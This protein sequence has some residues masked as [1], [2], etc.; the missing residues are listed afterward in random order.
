[1]AHWQSYRI[2]RA[3]IGIAPQGRRTFPNLTVKENLLIGVRSPH[4]AAA[5][6]HTVYTLFLRLREREKQRAANLSGGEQSMLAVGRSL[7]TNP[8]L[9][10]LDEPSEGLAP[11]IGWQIAGVIRQLRE[12]GVSVLIVE[13]NTAL[14]LAVADNVYILQKGQIAFETAPEA[15]R[16]D[17]P[18][19]QRYLSV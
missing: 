15:L 1:V 8:Q 11:R 18:L 5:G 14:A 16:S 6:L 19:L 10:L 3:G 4:E 17:R 9:L 7:M 13:Q 12:R 2:A